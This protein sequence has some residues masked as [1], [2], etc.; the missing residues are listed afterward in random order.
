MGALR[1]YCADCRD[2]PSTLAGVDA[3]VTDPP[4]GMAWN[5]KTARS[6]GGHRYTVKKRGG[7][8]DDWSNVINDDHAFD[9][10]P[11]LDYPHVVL[12]GC[13]HFGQRLPVGTTLVW[14]KRLDDAFGSFLSDAEVAWV[15]GNHGVYRHRNMTLLSTTN[16][17]HHPTEKPTA[18]MRWSIEK[19]CGDGTILDPF[20]G[21]GTTII[22]AGQTGRAC[23]AIEIS[24]HYVD[25]AVR[26]WEAFTGLSATLDTDG[27]T[28]AA[29][30]VVRT[31][32][33]SDD[34]RLPAAAQAAE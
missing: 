25:V 7:G 9:P 8:R 15:K 5:T 11:W 14:I 31:A 32:R 16:D 17:R 22:A 27:R 24:P 12:W 30:T 10:T 20:A 6:S 21:Y 13:N 28:F 19:A 29:V 4:Y 33:P 26:R 34:E 23:H 3:V 18:I 1:L 2:V